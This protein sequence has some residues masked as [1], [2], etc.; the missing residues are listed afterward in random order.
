MKTILIPTDF[1][2]NSWNA[3]E[4]AV[5][6]FKDIPCNFY[7]LHIGRIDQSGVE[8]NS[9]TMQ[10]TRLDAP[11]KKKLSKL[12]IRIDSLITNIPHNFI[13]LQEYGDLPNDP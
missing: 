9:F 10:F 2:D 3:V 12:V 1:S 4:Y 8:S 6:L 13:A 5:R 11:V 7:V